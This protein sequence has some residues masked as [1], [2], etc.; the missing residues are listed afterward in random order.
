[1]SGK[2]ILFLV[3]DFAEDY[4]VM[5]PFQALTMLGHIVHAV[6]PGKKAGEKIKTAIH[7]FK[8]D[9]TYTEKRGHNRAERQFCRGESRSP[10]RPDDRRGPRTGIPPARQSSDRHGPIIRWREQA[11]RGYLPCGANSCGGRRDPRATG[12]GLCRLR[13]ASSHGGRGICPSETA[14]S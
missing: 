9:Q 2:K 4:E 7:D 11:H 1:M 14:I 12:L 5:V 10:R 3:G 6:C 8:G 13:A